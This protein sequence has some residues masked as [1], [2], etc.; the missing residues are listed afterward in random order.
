MIAEIRGLPDHLRIV[1][2][3]LAGWERWRDQ[4]LA[5]RTLIRQAYDQDEAI[6]ADVERR[7]AE[8][9]AYEMVVFG[10]VYEPRERVGRPA[11]WWP[12]IPYA[13][14]VQMLRFIDEVYAAM[15]GTKGAQLG[16]GDGV[17]EKARGMAGSWTACIWAAHAWRHKPSIVIG[18]MSYK[19]DLVDKTDSTDALFYKIEG[20][21]GVDERVPATIEMEL[22][23]EVV[24]VPLRSPAS[25]LPDGFGPEHNRDLTLSHPTKT[26]LIT[27]YSTTG[28]STTGGRLSILFMDEGA[29]FTAFRVVWNQATA[30]TDHR[31]TFSS[32]DMTY[33]TGFRDV[34]RHAENAQ[35]TG[36]P[37]P[38]FLRLGV[39]LHPERDS[40]WAEMTK[41][42]HAADPFAEQS[43]QREYELNYEAGHGWHIYPYAR[44]LSVQPLTFNPADMSIDCCLDPGI[45]DMCAFHLVT[46]DPY[47][48]RYG[49]YRSYAKNGVG[50]AFYASIM[51][52]LPLAD[53][54]YTEE[55][56][57]LMEVFARVSRHV[58]FWI[59][60][61]AGKARSQATG[62]SF[63]DEL[64]T[65]S[66][67]LTDGQ[68]TIRFWS[69]DRSQYKHLT[70]RHEALRWLLPLLDV[71]D[72]P[73]TARTLEAI[74][75]HRFPAEVEGGAERTTVNAQPVR[76]WGHDRVTALEFYACHRRLG[77]DDPSTPRP[78]ATS[79]R[80]TMSGKP[81]ARR[82][83]PATFAPA[84]SR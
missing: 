45:R 51:L 8:D 36:G 78:K 42:R 73:Q 80:R 52:G 29:K 16:R 72:T 56:E 41:A 65:A 50:A 49:L 48:G 59:G 25:R 19:E 69:S 70:P 3:D 26:N 40:L 7:C 4:A 11:G 61:P 66:H 77:G 81:Y 17:I 76:T 71:N 6:R 14:Q 63:Y 22:E 75:D 53:A 83:A 62:T 32:A 35:K 10:C 31:L 68:R 27:G 60:D 34:A 58:R 37:G 55:E 44:K 67:A 79:Y 20:Y 12:A 46:Y 1:P 2:D 39:D 64:A 23:G 33:G 82:S 43:Y 84:R 30:V 24:A 57:E 13:F 74:K 18:F 5:Y 21:L 28:R 15:P 38:A 9:A 54:E 47:L